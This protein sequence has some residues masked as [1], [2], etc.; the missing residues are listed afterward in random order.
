M[1]SKNLP[2]FRRRFEIFG[3]AIAQS[4]FFGNELSGLNTQQC[5]VGF[6]VFTR[7]EMGVVGRDDF[8]IQFSGNLDQL[9]IDY[10][11]FRRT[12]ILNFNVVI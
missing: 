8:D 11:I 12:M 1:I 7:D 3:T 2:H 5:I 10:A 4:L 6:D 9:D